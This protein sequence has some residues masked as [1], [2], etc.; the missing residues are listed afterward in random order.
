MHWI[1]GAENSVCVLDAGESLIRMQEEFSESN[2]DV[3]S[4]LS[5]D[6]D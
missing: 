4:R 6:D 1:F 3:S 2:P 5:P